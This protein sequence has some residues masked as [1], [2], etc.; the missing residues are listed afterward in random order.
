MV[1]NNMPESETL[2]QWSSRLFLLAGVFLLVAVSNGSLA[3]LIEDYTFIDW[4]GLAG[5]VGTLIAL[6]GTGGLYVQLV[7]RTARLANLGLVVVAVAIVFSILSLAFEILE[8]AGFASDLSTVVGIG[9]FVLSVVAFSLFGFGIIRTGA[10]STLLGMLL[11]DAGVAMLIGF[12]GPE[13][14]DAGSEESIQLL[15]EGILVLLY[16]GIGYLLRTEQTPSRRTE[17]L[18]D[19]TP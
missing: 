19:A 7:N 12:F 15:M 1:T 11:M 5:L 16:L 4:V 3:F 13:I 17:P 2:E 9:S 14:P 10:Y 18:T 8:I 6:V